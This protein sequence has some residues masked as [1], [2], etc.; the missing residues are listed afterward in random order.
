MRE[1]Q[2]KA[3]AYRSKLG[4][5]HELDAAVTLAED[6]AYPRLNYMAMSS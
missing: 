4:N 2:V 5:P 3:M 1:L 6:I